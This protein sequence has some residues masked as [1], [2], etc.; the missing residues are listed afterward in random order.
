M[1]YTQTVRNDLSGC[2]MYTYTTGYN[3]NVSGGENETTTLFYKQTMARTINDCP[4]IFHFFDIFESR[5]VVRT[6]SHQ[7]FPSEA[8]ASFWIHGQ[9]V[10]DESKC[11]CSGITSGCKDELRTMTEIKEGRYLIKY[12]TFEEP[13][14]GK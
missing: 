4:Q 13:S 10:D 6:D 3:R 7:D 2:D 9:K 8:R 12:S 14:A 1:D 11:R 5:H